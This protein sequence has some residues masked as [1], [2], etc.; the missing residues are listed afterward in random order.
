MSGAV[1][2]IRILVTGGD[3]F[4]GRH[5]VRALS[6]SLPAG[7]QIIVGAHG[8]TAQ[9]PDSVRS[10][11]LDVTDFDEVRLV[12]A[13]ERPT[14]LFHLA[15]VASVGDQSRDARQVWSV[16][17]N[18]ALNIA[19]AVADV[20]PD[21]RILHCSSAQIYGVGHDPSLPLDESTPFDPINAYGA[22]KAAADLMMGQM[23]REGLRVVRLRPFNHTGPGQGGQFAAP[24]FAAQIARIERGE[25]EP[26]L[27]VGTLDSRRDFLD[28]RDV[29]DAYQRAVLR[30]DDL[31]E[32]CTMNIASGK[33]TSIGEV[34]AMLLAMSKS[35]ID[36]REDPALVRSNDASIIV[37]NANLA[38]RLLDWEPRI[39]LRTTLADLLEEHR[40]AP[41]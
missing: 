23:A 27:R 16:N 32:C 35:K 28:V 12:L 4:V 21:C 15:G 22:S 14:H 10:V 40:A 19:L 3:G 24:A 2:S 25:Q 20:L 11:P 36:V 18:G 38:R 7:C 1:A 8:G 37:G 9:R 17:F 6:A 33:A 30:F 34:L 13:N 5:L 41:Q 29:V 39:P 26:V 31:P